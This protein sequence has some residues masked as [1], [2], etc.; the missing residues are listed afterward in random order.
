MKFAF[1]LPIH[2]VHTTAA[3]LLNLVHHI[4]TAVVRRRT[5]FSRPTKVSTKFSASQI[6]KRSAAAGTAE[7]TF[8]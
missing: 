2:T 4:D 3:D 5:K 6:R 1:L 8:P 7:C